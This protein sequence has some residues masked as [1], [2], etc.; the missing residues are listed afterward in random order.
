MTCKNMIFTSVGDNT[1][2]QDIWIADEMNYDIYAIYYGNNEDVFENYK[3]KVK[4]IEKRKG[5]KFQNFKYFYS[6]YPEIIDK[7][8]Y[9]F[10]LDDDILISVSDINEMFDIADK[11]KLSICGPS[12]SN[13]VISHGITKHCVNRLLTY[14]NFVEVNVPLFS[15]ISLE[16]FMQK[17]DCSLIGWGIDFL[18]IW[19]NGMDKQKDYAII[20]KIKCENPQ[21]TM[22]ELHNCEGHANRISDWKRYAT[23]INCPF[24]FIPL[25]YS[26]VKL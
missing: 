15:K 22:R 2:F 8:D 3:A 25:E 7:Y 5:S 17:L 14:T 20:H 21:K 19:C 18:Y 13:G 11:Y 23:K 6:H 26:S 9:F 24:T 1:S 4:F 16:K 12:F 10:I